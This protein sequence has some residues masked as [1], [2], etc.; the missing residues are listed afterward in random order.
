M[1]VPKEL[2]EQ[3]NR[4]PLTPDAV[5]LLVKNNLEVSVETGA[6]EKANFSD[7]EYSNAGARIVYNH[8]EIFENDIIL[9]IDPL[10]NE[11]FDIIKPNTTLIS[12]LNLPFLSK[13][14]FENLNK[15]KLQP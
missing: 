6:G 13:E 11:E 1:G 14:Y 3:E 7:I 12:T 4:V 5:G 10:V 8:K 9:K 2:S 15:R